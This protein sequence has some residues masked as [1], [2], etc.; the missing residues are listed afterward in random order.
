M[1]SMEKNEW[2]SLDKITLEGQVVGM[3]KDDEALEA[4]GW[5]GKISV[6]D[7]KRSIKI[8]LAS[9]LLSDRKSVV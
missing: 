5:S 1:I 8:A 9:L 6:K 4:V 2:S 3:K 7:G